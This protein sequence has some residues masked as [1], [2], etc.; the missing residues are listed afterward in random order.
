M[1]KGLITSIK[2]KQKM[3]KTHFI[4]GTS[5]NKLYYKKY[6]NILTRLKDLAKIFYYH[7]KLNEYKD[8]P[9]QTW[10]ILRSLL[11]SKNNNLIPDSITVNNS[12]IS[13]LNQ[14]SEEF[15]NHFAN[16]GKSLANSLKNNNTNDESIY[17]K[18]PCLTS[19]YL[20]PTTPLEIMVLINSLKL[21]KAISHD[22]IDPYFLKIAAPILAFPL[23][24]FPN[25]CLTFG[26]F[27]NRLK[28]AKVVPVFKKGL[29]D[30]LSNYR[31]ISLLPSL[32][33]LFERIIHSR[34]LSFF[35]YNNTIVTTQ[36]GFRHNH[37]T[38]HPIL[39]LITSCFDNIKNK[40]YSLYLIVFG[41]K[42]GF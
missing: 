7:H 31:P 20:E 18:H 13:D 21:N 23:S 10:K 32:S 19:I 34:L 6:S 17:P 41:C 15:N 26:T 24:V 39:D 35:E 14:I 4:L 42:E 22:D 37:S 36:Y 11:P 1:T 5:V 9:T 16:V 40:K 38:I 12:S 3:H 30:Q 33:K 28:L 8:S 2:K 29:T 27:P 25:H